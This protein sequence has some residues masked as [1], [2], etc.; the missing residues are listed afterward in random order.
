[1]INILSDEQVQRILDALKKMLDA[2]N[3]SF[4]IQIKVPE[5]IQ[6]AALRENFDQEEVW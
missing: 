4:V 3:C 6:Y 1:M 5:R 2:Y